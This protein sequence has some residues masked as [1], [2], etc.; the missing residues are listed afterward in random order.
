MIDES[1]PIPRSA[2]PLCLG[3]MAPVV[4]TVLKTHDPLSFQAVADAVVHEVGGDPS[5]GNNERTL[6]RRV[7]DVLNVF[8]AAGIAAKQGKTL[9]WIRTHIRPSANSVPQS[10]YASIQMREIELIDKISIFVTWKLLM[11]AN[12]TRPK[13]P[14]AVPVWKTLFVGFR[15]CSGGYDGKFDRRKV[16]IHAQSPPLFF[17]PLEVIAKL[18]FTRDQK[19][20][21]LLAERQLQ[22]AVPIMFP[23]CEG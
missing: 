13:P 8:L 15:T 16:M 12:R 10:L 22:D 6:R 4:L 5:I 1:V 3:R 21:I 9:V 19:K 11:D 20:A 7:Y 17:S 2:K 18:G 14:I 23:E